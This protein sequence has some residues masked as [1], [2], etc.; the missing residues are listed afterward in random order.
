MDLFLSAGNTDSSPLDTILKKSQ[1]LP[2]WKSTTDPSYIISPLLLLDLPSDRFPRGFQ[3]K[4]S[5]N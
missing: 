3:P 5:M 1:A 2:S 4:L